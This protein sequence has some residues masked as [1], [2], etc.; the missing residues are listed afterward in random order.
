[1]H[2]LPSPLAGLHGYAAE[3]LALFRRMQVRPNAARRKLI[4]RTI[5]DLK[6]HGFWDELDLLYF[7]AAHTSQ[8]ALL[9][10]KGQAQFDGVLSPSPVWWEV[11][12]GFSRLYDQSEINTSWNAVS[13]GVNYQLGDASFS[14]WTWGG[15]STFPGGVVES[16][17]YAGSYLKLTPRDSGIAS[18]AACN[19]DL[20][21]NTGITVDERDGLWTVQRVSAGNANAF[22]RRNAVDVGAANARPAQLS[23]G[24]VTLVNGTGGVRFFA[25][26]KSRTAAREA[27]FYSIIAAYMAAVD[28]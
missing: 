5:V 4:Q 2:P 18:A 7:F 14:V 28:A 10:W 24:A 11:D 23:P 17:S 3:S 9:N 12:Q 8:A 16:G 6:Y 25:L 26:G 20:T 27:L 22:I 19:M 15:G 1:M 21:P 13:H